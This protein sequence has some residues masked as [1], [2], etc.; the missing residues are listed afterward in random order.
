MSATAAEETSPTPSEQ[1]ERPPRRSAAAASPRKAVIGVIGLVITIWLFANLFIF[2][3]DFDPPKLVQALVAIIGGVGGAMLL[4][5]FINQLVES[6]P[7]KLSVRVIPYAFLLPALGLL[8]SFMIFPTFQTIVYSFA[9]EDSTA[10]VGFDNYTDVLSDPEFINTI[11]NTLLWLAIVPITTVILGLIV[12]VLADKLSGTGEKVAKS[13]IFLPM[14]ISMVGAAT[15]WRFVYAFAPEGRPQIGLL[16]AFWTTLGF[17]PVSW[18]QVTTLNFNDVLLMVILI[19]LQAGFAMV[20][21]SA[22]IKGVPEDTLEAARIDGATEV[23]IFF[24]VV[25][26]QIRGT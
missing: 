17:D 26:P 5:Y 13:M 6:L 18:L 9:N 23:K 3:K 25:I 8:A 24:Q 10:W 20:L 2:L 12:A 22:A 14:A 1:P 19:W 15:I 21:L 4:F 16:N 7:L 11:T